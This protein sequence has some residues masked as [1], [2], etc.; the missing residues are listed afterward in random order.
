MQFFSFTSFFCCNRDLNLR[1]SGCEADTLITTTNQWMKVLRG[2]HKNGLQ[3]SRWAPFDAEDPMVII[4]TNTPASA[5][6]LVKPTSF[7][8]WLK[9]LHMQDG[10]TTIFQ[11]Q[12]VNLESNFFLKIV[13]IYL[14][15]NFLHFVLKFFCFML[16]GC[17]VNVVSSAMHYSYNIHNYFLQ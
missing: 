10:T 9:I 4:L 1:P 6:K 7:Q 14:H 5:L 16:V 8:T 15:K 3:E 17:S 11:T 2:G 13:F 12:G